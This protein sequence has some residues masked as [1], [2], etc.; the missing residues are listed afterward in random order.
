MNSYSFLAIGK[1]HE[2]KESVSTKRYIGV[3][4]SYVIAVNPTKKELEN[5]YGR[6]IANEPIYVKED[7]EVPTVRIDFI[8]KTDPEQCNGI[9]TVNHA[10]MLLVNEPAYNS[11]KTK[12][13]IIDEYGNTTWAPVED[14]KM[15]V[16]IQHNGMD[17]KIAPKYRMACRGEADLVDFLRNYLG[18][19]DAFTYTNGSWTIKDGNLDDYKFSLEHIK[20]YFKGDVSELK[21]ALTLQPKNKLKLLYGVRTTDNGQYQAVC[22]RNGM[23]LRNNATAKGLTRL[24]KQIAGMNSTNT[25]YRVCPLQEYVVAPT[26]LNTPV[27]TAAATAGSESD[28]PWD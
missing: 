2:S 7:A 13:Q 4:S 16:R 11:D 23:T 20:D 22:T 14:A 28:M 18:V 3:G 8:V 1:T 25:E 17:A 26:D 24:E 10:S 12:V 21:E 6:E 27:E 5:I 9:E 19:D 15:N